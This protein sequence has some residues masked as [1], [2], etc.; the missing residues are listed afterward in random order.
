MH[1]AEP[2]NSTDKKTRQLVIT[3]LMIC[4][5]VLGTIL[6]RIPVPMTKGYIHLGDGMVYLAA[7]L[8]GKKNGAVV[9]G[10][11]SALGDILGG[12][13]FWAPFSFVIKLAMAFIA[14]S[15]IE[16]HHGKHEQG[17]L[18]R[19]LLYISGMTAGGL[20]MCAGY[21]VVERFMYGSWAPALIGVPWN[22]GQF[23]VGIVIALAVYQTLSRIGFLT[24]I[25]S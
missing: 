10:L 22:I 6:F 2:Q 7:L 13:A 18:R 9:A 25:N 8:L 24:G 3:A 11:G 12:F 4:L 15:I 20:V 17:S 1:V 16:L 23:A 14:A 19:T 21:L 5:V